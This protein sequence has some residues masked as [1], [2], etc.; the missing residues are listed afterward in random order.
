MKINRFIGGVFLISGTTI[1]AGML[2]LPL[3]T[4]F[5]GLIPSIVVF[6]VCWLS[7]L[8]SAFFLL[9]VNFSVKGQAN[10]ISMASSTLGPFGKYLSWIAYLLLLYLLTAAYIAAGAPL[11]QMGVFSFTSYLVPSHISYFF[12]PV[13][14]GGLVYFGISFVDSL[15]RLLMVGLCLS[16]LLIIG[17][18]TRHIEPHLLERANWNSTFITLPVIITSFGYHIIIP[19]LKSYMNHNK[20]QLRWAL[21]IGSL[22]P[23]I[24]YILWELVTLGTIPLEGKFGLIQASKEGV[25]IT[26]SLTQIVKN[27]WVNVGAHFFSFFAIVTSF[28]GVSLSLSDF[29]KDGLKLKKTVQGR[30]F[31][32]L[33][34][35]V[36][37]LVFV[38]TY[39]RGFIAALEYAG[40]FVAILLILMPS[41]MA[42]RLKRP[43][44]YQTGYGCLLLIFTTL[45][46]LFVVAIDVLS[47]WG[48]F[49]GFTRY[50]HI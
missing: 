4:S 12:L 17:S 26:S 21:F 20:K 31:A 38:F 28:L 9:D 6:G 42:C 30:L 23:L 41:V 3:T 11:F 48:F 45:F 27:R 19:S 39:P 36:P 40:A 37:P 8:A 10:L 47:Q 25:P 50:A 43:K 2:A 5:I 14:F 16:Y 32:T 34:T 49:N 44:F 7:M 29:L 46:A 22:L 18:L 24:V 1:G 33:L 13:L 35:F 15:N